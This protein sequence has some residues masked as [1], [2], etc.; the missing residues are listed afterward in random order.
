MSN[1]Q[2]QANPKNDQQPVKPIAADNK[3]GV[4]KNADDS[5]C[6]SADAAKSDKA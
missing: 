4:A 6:T 2:P 1:N 3:A 5:A